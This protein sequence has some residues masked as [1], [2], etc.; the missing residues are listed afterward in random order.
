VEEI[1]AQ[2]KQ[3]LFAA[4][5]EANKRDIASFDGQ[6]SGDPAKQGAELGNND[7]TLVC[8]IVGENILVADVLNLSHE[9]DHISN[10]GTESRIDNDSV[11]CF[12]EVVH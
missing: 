9:I 12:L 1:V 11:D 2:L 4:F 5:G 6:S 3:H 10:F 8:D 7:Q